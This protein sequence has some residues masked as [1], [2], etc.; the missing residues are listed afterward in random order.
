MSPSKLGARFLAVL[1]TAA[2]GLA[3]GCYATTSHKAEVALN[4]APRACTNVVAGVFA[5]AGFKQV[6]TPPRMSMLFAAKTSGLYD[7]FLT[8]GTAVGVTVVQ[9]MGA[10]TCHVTIEAVSP[11]V[12]C[13]EMHGPLRCGY[14]GMDEVTGTRTYIGPISPG[15]PPCPIVRPAVCELSNAPGEANDHAVDEL[16]RRVQSALGPTSTVN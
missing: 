3:S 16:A 9:G 7:S 15:S 8:T 6:P 14:G 2:A 4:V 11:D 1:A 12:N 5:D 13:P 10:D